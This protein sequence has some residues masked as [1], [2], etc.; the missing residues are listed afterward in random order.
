[1]SPVKLSLLVTGGLVVGFMVTLLITGLVQ[2]YRVQHRP[3]QKLFQA[4]TIPEPLPDG[5]YQ[6]NHFTG[7]GKDWQGKVFD[8]VA[9]AGIN[10]FANGQR[11]TF[12]TYQTAGLRD[13]SQQVL[14]IDY[15]RPG[16]PWWLRFIVDE[17][18]QTEPGH[19]LGKVHLRVMPG[20]VFT[21]TYF[22]LTQTP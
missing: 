14:R 10:Q 11:F 7:F 16:N 20:V 19:Y 6:G 22:E 2:T 1:M 8:R 3:S 13:K 5:F 18:V 12:T 17:I 4:G 21:L 15:K 9:Q